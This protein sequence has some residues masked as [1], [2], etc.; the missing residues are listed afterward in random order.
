MELYKSL[1]F[2]DNPFSTFSA[3]EEKAF[4]NKIYINPLFYNTLK[5][6]LQKGLSRFILGARGIGKTA[7]LL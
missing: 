4:L 6:D 2:T 3:E 5:S 1:G 7:L